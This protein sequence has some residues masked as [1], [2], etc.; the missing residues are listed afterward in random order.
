MA[1]LLKFYLARLLFEILIFFY[2]S[3]ESA[4]IFLGKVSTRASKYYERDQIC[5]CANI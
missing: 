4:L 3:K 2:N 5:L 1:L